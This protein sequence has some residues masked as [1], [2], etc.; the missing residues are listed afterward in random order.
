M[1]SRG[2]GEGV[3]ERQPGYRRSSARKVWLTVETDVGFAITIAAPA[4]RAA[5]AVVASLV[6]PTISSSG[7]TACSDAMRLT[8]T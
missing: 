8:G 5:R 4:L 2:S 7:S 3:E 1:S 6:K